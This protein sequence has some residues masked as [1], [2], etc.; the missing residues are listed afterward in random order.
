MKVVLK[1]GTEIE[2]TTLDAVLAR[3][4]DGWQN[5][6]VFTLTNGQR[7]VVTD[8]DQVLGDRDAASRST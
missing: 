3:P 4:F 6:T 1:P 7:W 8:D 2:Y 5:G